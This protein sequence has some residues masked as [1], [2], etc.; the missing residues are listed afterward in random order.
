LEQAAKHNPDIILLDIRMPDMD[1]RETLAALRH[2]ERFSHIPVVSVTAS[3]MMA[4]ELELRREFDGYIR[5][6][7]TRAQLFREIAAILPRRES[8]AEPAPPPAEAHASGAAVPAQIT[9][10]D[11]VRPEWKPLLQ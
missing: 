4:E 1:G 3:S 6:P 2:D 9:R 7:F 10:P 8:D 11:P 5:K